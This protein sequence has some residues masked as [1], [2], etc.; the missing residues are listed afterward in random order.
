MSEAKRSP[1]R[2]KKCA[3]TRE[4]ARAS[5]ARGRTA[6]ARCQRQPFAQK[7]DAFRMSGHP[8]PHGV[9]KYRSRYLAHAKRALYHLSYDPDRGKRRIIRRY[10]PSDRWRTHKDPGTW[11]NRARAQSYG[12][13]VSTTRGPT[14]ERSLPAPSRQSP[15]RDVASNDRVG[16]RERETEALGRRR[17]VADGAAARFR[18]VAAMRDLRRV[19]RHAG[20]VSRV[21]ARVLLRLRA[22]IAADDAQVYD[23]PRTGR[24]IRFS[25]G[26]GAGGGGG[27]I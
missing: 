21:S 15:A 13:F 26:E 4:R 1:Y 11:Q 19:L 17:G 18:R 25:P 9:A 24:R 2:N 5:S 27:E 22:K 23:L 20:D 14:P 16:V 6:S 3:R 12:L 8:S 10:A 7:K